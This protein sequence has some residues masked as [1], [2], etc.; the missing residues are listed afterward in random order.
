MNVENNNLI[1]GELFK[2]LISE[3]PNFAKMYT[4]V[5]DYLQDI[6]NKTLAGKD[7]INVSFK[8]KSPLAK[9]AKKLRNNLNIKENK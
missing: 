3:N 5:P 9:W 4:E 6:A 1:S 8:S 7:E 2:K